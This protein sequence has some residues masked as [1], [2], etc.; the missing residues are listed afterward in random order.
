MF[1][2]YGEKCLSSKTVHKW[3]GKRGKIFIYDEKVETEVWYWL[4]QQSKEYYAAGF[5]ALVKR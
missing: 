1:P 4:R 2:V 3:V 5:E